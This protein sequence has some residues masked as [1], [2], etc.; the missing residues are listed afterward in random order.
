MQKD[1]LFDNIYIGHSV[2]EAEALKAQTYDV[3]S[4]IEEGDKEKTKPKDAEKPKSP[5]DL[6]FKDDPVLYVKEKFSLFVTIAQ[7]DPMEAVR[8]VPE[9]AGGLAVLAVTLL[10]AIISLLVGGG[11]A[12]ESAQKAA[13]K[14]KEKAAE[15][16]DEVSKAAS[17]GVEKVQEVSKRTTRSSAATQQE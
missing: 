3:K 13:E 1:I 11:A 7:R 8:F 9:V 14:T 5:M 2:A 6:K 17:S 15:A 12:P 10:V 16:K 4:P